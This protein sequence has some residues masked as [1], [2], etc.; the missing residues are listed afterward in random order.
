M[1][2]GGCLSLELENRGELFERYL[3]GKIARFNCGRNAIAAVVLSLKP[4]KIWLPY[5]NCAVVRETLTKYKIPVSFYYLDENM[6]PMLENIGAE[7]WILYVNYFGIASCQK[8]E[9]IATK[10]A[11][12]IFD[13]TQALFAEPVFLEQCF[14]VY[15]PRK[16]VGVA[17]GSY[18]VWDNK[19]EINQEYPVDVS[20]N[21][22]NFLFKS[23]ELGIN[24][25]Y[26]ESQNSK[27]VFDDGIK[28][29]SL[30]TRKMLSSIDYDR[31]R[32][33]RTR[34]YNILYDRL[35]EINQI[36]PPEN[37]SGPFVY[38]L[39]VEKLNLRKQLVNNKI[40]VSQWW[41][42]LLNEVSKESIERKYT[43]YLLPIPLD[44]RCSE[45]DIENLASIIIKCVNTEG[46]RKNENVS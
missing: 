19:H 11:R 3:N 17:D 24:A 31:I 39:Y 43:Q 5:Y 36:C 34:N 42:Y 15:S 13:N 7:E 14:N 20:W 27:C 28:Q 29:M 6:E 18:V 37:V 1:E 23:M 45:N 4:K 26:E 35:R 41:L 44:Q 40:Y 2:Y 32:D 12:V 22:A 33:I 46:E 38:P 8:L 25:A 9:K 21:R 30:L 16:F 10:F